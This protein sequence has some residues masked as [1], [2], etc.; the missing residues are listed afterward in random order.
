MKD[1]EELQA[2]L[3][4]GHLLSVTFYNK[5]GVFDPKQI[6]LSPVPD[7]MLEIQL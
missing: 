5:F 7:H 3:S 2:L 4:S 6:E 1:R